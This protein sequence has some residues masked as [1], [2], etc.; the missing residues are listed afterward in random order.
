M[1]NATTGPLSSAPRADDDALPQ[2]DPVKNVLNDV[3]ETAREQLNAAWQIEIERVQE[4]LAAGW[5]EHIERVFEERFVELSARVEVEFG[6]GVRA[7]VSDTRARTRREVA[8]KLNQAVRRLRFFENE[9]QWSRA[10]V[11]ATESFCERAALFIVNGPALRLQASRGVPSDAK[12][13]NTPVESAPA[14]AGAVQSRDTI[15]ALRTRGEL[16]DVI[17]D[18]LGEA[19]E[20]R[21]Y[22]FPIP[23][24]ERV[25]AVLYT[26]SGS[27]GEDTAV[28]EALELMAVFASAVLE[29]QPETPDKSKL[30]RIATER[31]PAPTVALWFSLSKEEQEL[32]LRAQRFARVQVAEM[33][34]YKAQAV[35][36]GRLERDLYGALREDVDRARDAFRKDYLSASPT[37]VDYVHL[38]LLRTLANDDVE[39]LGPEYPGAMA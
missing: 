10:L 13:D 27:Y 17:A 32:H 30:V 37:M 6:A 24:H 12:I 36:A 1:A 23:V 5:R 3:R 25:A 21:F 4:Q 34:L 28:T 16:S 2:T 29:G 33:R 11:D 19:S 22:L 7:A 31:Q 38:E 14:F 8:G 18:V 20:Q 9:D 15:V 26:D 39:L 35:K